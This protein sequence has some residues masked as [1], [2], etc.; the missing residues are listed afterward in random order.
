VSRILLVTDQW[1][2]GS[3]T[4]AMAI[5]DDLG[6]LADD[7]GSIDRWLVGDGAG[8]ELARH[9]ERR[10]S[11]STFEG[12][13]R[14]DTQS[15]RLNADLDDTIRKSRVVVSVQNRRMALRAAAC[16]TPCVY[17][18]SLLW[19][20]ERPPVPLTVSQ[21]FVQRFPGV[22]ARVQRWRSELPPTQVIGP[23]IAAWRP[24]KPD[25]QAGILV[26][27]GGLSSWYVSHE[28]LV[29]YAATMTQCVARAF[30]RW[31]GPITVCVGEHVLGD[32]GDLPSRLASSNVRL[33]NLDHRDYLAEL[34]RSRLLVS[35]AG[36]HAVYEAF[37]SG[38]PCIL[39]PSQNLSGARGW[40]RLARAGVT[41]RLDWDTL[42]GLRFRGVAEEELA[43]A[44]IAQCIERFQHDELA[45]ARLVGHLGAASSKPELE[46][47]AAVQ[48]AFFHRMGSTRGSIRVADYLSELIG[49]SRP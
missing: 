4:V 45:M 9:Q 24:A 48:T 37:A 30:E 36:I 7:E 34:R 23:T 17:V 49:A 22:E 33:W 38:V 1:G 47:L 28:T 44:E 42:Y 14:A 25:R 3:T 29:A 32:I 11:K 43:C 26:N 12:F 15:R 19:L 41:S 35:S 13:V 8:F 39:L 2:Y 20:W 46:R 18:D 10:Q 5:A 6:G 40:Q 21:Y 27:F 16:K 31:P